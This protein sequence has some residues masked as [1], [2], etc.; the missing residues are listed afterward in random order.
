MRVNAKGRWTLS[1]YILPPP[2]F[3]AWR[4]LRCVVDVVRMSTEPIKQCHDAGEDAC[5]N[6]LAYLERVQF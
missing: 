3:A 1:P 6:V 4:L 5:E 2:A